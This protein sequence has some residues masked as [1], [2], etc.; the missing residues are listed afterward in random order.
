MMRLGYF[1]A[2]AYALVSAATARAAEVD[3]SR[4][5]STLGRPASV[6]PDGVH[7]FGFPRTD[8]HVTV[9][10]V[11]LRAAFALGSWLAFKEMGERA[12]VMGD[13]VLLENEVTP[14]RERLLKGGI[15]VT[16][17]H[18]HMLR[19]RPMPMYM[20]VLGSGDAVA[21]AETLHAALMASRTPLGTS[22]RPALQPNPTLDTA[23]LDTIIGRRGK[24][25]G[26]VY[27]FGI[28]RAE[29]IRMGELVVPPSMGAG[30]GINFEPSGA[31]KAAIT[32]DLPLLAQEVAPVMRALTRN[33]IEVTALHNHMLTENPRLF[34]M[35]F[36][37]DADAGTLARG[38]RAALDLMNLAPK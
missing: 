13:L 34:F 37:A 3:W 2:C 35:H 1:G 15:E 17:L 36:W 23:M 7:R 30:A 26:G 6:Q 14:V 31:G 29:T 38:I 18:N 27:Q 20:H 21:L 28:P 25:N 32:G 8:L 24:M 33:G 19:A 4:V 11:P 16:A 9:D 5:E 12:V 10:G 22:T